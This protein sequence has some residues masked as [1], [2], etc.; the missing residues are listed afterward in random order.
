[1]GAEKK[2]RTRVAGMRTRG[3]PTTSSADDTVTS[4]P[5]NERAIASTLDNGDNTRNML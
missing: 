5:D 2:N 3:K 4:D 1:M